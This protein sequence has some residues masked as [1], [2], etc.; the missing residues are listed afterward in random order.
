MIE[1]DTFTGIDEDGVENYSRYY[2]N[3]IVHGYASKNGNGRGDG[4]C[5]Y[6]S[7]WFFVSY[8]KGESDDV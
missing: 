4:G 3:Q 7:R 8:I 6:D 2:S 5:Y 1:F